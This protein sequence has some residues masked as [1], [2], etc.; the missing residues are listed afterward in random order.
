MNTSERSQA[1]YDLH[2]HSYL[3]SFP[4]ST[5]RIVLS[6]TSFLWGDPTRTPA[7]ISRNSL[8]ATGA[9]MSGLMSFWAVWLCDGGVI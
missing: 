9:L 6:T 4:Q 5:G 7:A 8:A 3:P 2:L 1:Q